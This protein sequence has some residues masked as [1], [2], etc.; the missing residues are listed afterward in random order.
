MVTYVGKFIP[1]LSEVTAPL[2]MLTM[3]EI[4]WHWDKSQEEAYEKLINI[5]IKS[6]VLAIYN[7]HKEMT[8][9]ADASKSGLG[10][11]IFQNQKPIEY[12]SKALTETEENYAQIEKELLA[13]VF[14]CER[15][16][17]CIYLRKH[18]KLKQIT[19]PY[20]QFSKRQ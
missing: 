17:Q 11:V 6:P 15:F 8:I 4:T 19:S 1:N 7:P 10:V 13:I 16:H 12:A 14:T 20:K 9:S 18:F 3:K 5:I 2:R